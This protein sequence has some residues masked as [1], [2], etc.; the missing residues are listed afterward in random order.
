LMLQDRSKGHTG[1]IMFQPAGWRRLPIVAFMLILNACVPGLGYP[2]NAFY[3]VP[4]S[5]D[6]PEGHRPP[7]GSCRVWYPDR[8]PGHQP[9]P[10]P[11][12]KLRYRVP[13]GAFLV[14]G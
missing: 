6:M 9:P 2:E 8:P 13:Q 12:N 1:E 3:G 14:Y 11:C 10:G 5:P 7:P 4:S